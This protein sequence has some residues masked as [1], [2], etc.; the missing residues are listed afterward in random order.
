M[1]KINPQAKES[2]EQL[3]AVWRE[4]VDDRGVGEIRDLPG[5]V[6]RWSD[7]G[8]A[9]F[10]TITFTDFGADSKLL[11][12]RMQ[13]AAGYL[14]QKRQPGLIWLFEDFLNPEGRGE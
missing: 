3:A 9:F 12:S 1:L 14:R 11:D 10:N 7:T 5:M 13:V 6:I 8:F 4:I 2:V